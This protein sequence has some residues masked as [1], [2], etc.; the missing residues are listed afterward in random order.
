MRKAARARQ[1]ILA[2]FLP[3]AAVLYIRLRGAGS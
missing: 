2:A 1:R 3:I